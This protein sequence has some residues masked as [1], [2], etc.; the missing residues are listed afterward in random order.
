[1]SEARKDMAPWELHFVNFQQTKFRNL[2]TLTDFQRRS[3][4]QVL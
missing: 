4:Q 3:F 1:M 2:A